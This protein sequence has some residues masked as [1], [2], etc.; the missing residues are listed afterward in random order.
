[1]ENNKV[2]PAEWSYVKIKDKK[3]KLD[4]FRIFPESGILPP[5]GKQ[6]IKVMFV[7]N[8]GKK[9][10]QN[11]EFKIKS[12]EVCKFVNVMGTSSIPKVAFNTTQISIDTTLP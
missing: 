7:P 3:P 9:F 11:L 1:M 6:N 5:G 10:T 8:A 2:V 12:N 4:I